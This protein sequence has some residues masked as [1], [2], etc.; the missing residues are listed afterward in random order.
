MINGRR[1]KEGKKKVTMGDFVIIII[2]YSMVKNRNIDK[3]SLIGP[4]CGTN[5]PVPFEQ[6]FPFLP[7]ARIPFFSIKT[8]T[9][10]RRVSLSGHLSVAIRPNLM[11]LQPL[12]R[13]K[14]QI[15]AEG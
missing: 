10:L 14:S 7:S 6:D 15:T 13:R 11:G 12:I 5:F 8:C 2:Y 3:G 1:E 4:I 9:F